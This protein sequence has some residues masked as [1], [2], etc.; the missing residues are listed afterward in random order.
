MTYLK[1]EWIHHFDD[2][3]IEMLSELDGQRNEMRKVERFRDGSLSFAGPEGVSGTT[4]LSEGPVPE[5]Q[6]IASDPQ[7]HAVTIDKD[8]FEQCWKSATISVAA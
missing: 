4:V 1:V 2:E 8:A 7:F 5:V 3:P 6:E